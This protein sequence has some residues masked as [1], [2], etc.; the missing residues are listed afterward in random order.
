MTRK[1]VGKK[2]SLRQT[3]LQR[4]GDSLRNLTILFG[5][6]GIFAGKYQ[7]FVIL[8]SFPAFSGRF[9]S[10]KVVLF[11]VFLISEEEDLILGGERIK[12]RNP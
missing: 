3:N 6:I 9:S 11:P 8:N 10:F 1:L 5:G 4:I 7:Q 12:Y 2:R